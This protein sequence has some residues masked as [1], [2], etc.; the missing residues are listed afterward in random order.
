MG[1][2][3]TEGP[4][5]MCRFGTGDSMIEG[6]ADLGAGRPTRNGMIGDGIAED[7]ACVQQT[8]TASEDHAVP[9]RGRPTRWE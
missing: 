3:P 4:N 7:T 5:D 6:V 8:I 9:V 2:H 1:A